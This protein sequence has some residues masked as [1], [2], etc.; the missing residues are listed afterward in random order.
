MME[1]QKSFPF[2]AVWDYYC[3]KSG[4]P[5]GTDWLNEVRLYEKDVLLLRS[6]ASAPG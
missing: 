3:L 6:S 1:E 2:G 4:V 5:V